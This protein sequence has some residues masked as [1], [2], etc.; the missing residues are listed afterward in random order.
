MALYPVRQGDYE[1]A[2][3]HRLHAFEGISLG[4]ELNPK[5]VRPT[6]IMPPGGGGAFAVPVGEA[7]AVPVGGGGAIAVPI[8]SLHSYPNHPHHHIEG[9]VLP[10]EAVPEVVDSFTL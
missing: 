1:A 2:D 5:C 4:V 9:A 10:V 7:I 3:F 8:G 6:L